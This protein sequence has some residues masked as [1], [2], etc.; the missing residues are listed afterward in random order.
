MTVFAIIVLT[1]I[2]LL[3][4]VIWEELRTNSKNRSEDSLVSRLFGRLS[5]RRSP[6]R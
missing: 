5:G 3:G 4:G 1:M 2:I 6:K